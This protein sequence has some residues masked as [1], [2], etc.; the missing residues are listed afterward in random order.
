MLLTGMGDPYGKPLQLEYRESIAPNDASEWQS[1]HKAI[2]HEINVRLEQVKERIKADDKLLVCEISCN[3]TQDGKIVNL[4]VEGGCPPEPF[5]S[6]IS[7]DCPLPAFEQL[8][9]QKMSSL[10][11]SPLLKFP[12]GATVTDVNVSGRFSQNYG[13]KFKKTLKEGSQAP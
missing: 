2:E 12:S 1:W 4:R 5:H 9:L 3:V 11:G 8:A 7:P 6:R 13:P 10:E